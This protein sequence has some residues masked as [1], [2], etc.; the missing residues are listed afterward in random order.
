MMKTG[1]LVLLVLAVFSATARAADRQRLPHPLT[2]AAAKATRLGRL[3][4]T[5]NLNLV[6]ALPLRNR[7]ALTN[8]LQQIYDPAS[9]C[10]RH[11]LTPTQFTKMFGPTEQDYEAVAAFARASGFAV[12]GTHPNRM[13]LDVK[14][15]V[16]A[17]ENALH[18][19]MHEYRHP[20]ENRRFFAPDTAPSLDLTV[21]VL[22]ISGLDNFS[23]PCPRLVAAPLAKKP[24]R[25]AER[26]IGSGRRLHGQ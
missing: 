11:Y 4:A 25:R 23:L 3:P 10:Y 1:V 9:P 6:I 2:A 19:K 26:R 21:P 14:A 24:L 22:G 5:T 20:M 18:L 12:T 16:A 7:P 8:L 15:P 13:L 17:V